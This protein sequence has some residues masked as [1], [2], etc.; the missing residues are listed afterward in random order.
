MI[1]LLLLMIYFSTIFKKDDKEFQDDWIEYHRKNAILQ[2]L[3]KTF[4]L[5]RRENDY[6]KLFKEVII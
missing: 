6:I 1:S 5:K 3:C 2:C 4:N